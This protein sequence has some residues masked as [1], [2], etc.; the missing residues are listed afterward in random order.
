MFSRQVK[1]GIFVLEGLNSL[2]TVYYFYYFYFFLAEK[3]G[4]GDRQNLLVAAL[5]GGTY[6][7]SAILGG[8]YGQRRGYF[9]ALRFGYAVMAVSLFA[10]AWVSTLPAY[11]FLLVTCTF[12]M[13]FTWPNLEAMVSEQEPPLRLQRMVGIYN[14]VWSTCM[15]VSYFTGG[16]IKEWLGPR[17]IFLVPAFLYLGQLIL[18]EVLAKKA[19]LPRESKPEPDTVILTKVELNPRPI[20]RARTF[21][22]LAWLANPFAYIAVNSTVPTLPTLAH[23]LGFT[24]ALAGVFCSLWFFSRAASFLW[25]WLWPGWHYRFGWLLGAY[26]GLSISFS[27]ILLSTNLAILIVAQLLFGAS[28]GLIYY[29]SLFYS[30]DTSDTKGEHGGWHEAAIGAGNCA[31]PLLGALALFAFPGVSNGNAMAVGIVLFFGLLGLLK[32]YRSGLSPA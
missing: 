12:G 13:C 29:S 7:L 4:F 27:T 32:I 25:L 6:M 21:L 9:R 22:K 17:S 14:L 19:A 16:A 15:A 31:G 20:A 23:K 28:L 24:P 8:K 26:L 1:T 18:T 30:M 3:F 5:T 10:S 2:G 11:L